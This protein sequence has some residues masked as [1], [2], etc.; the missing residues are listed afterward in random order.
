MSLGA[1]RFRRSSRIL[2]AL[3][4]L[5]SSTALR[6]APLPPEPPTPP[7]V[8]APYVGD[9]GFRPG[10]YAWLRGMFDGATAT[11]VA[12]DAAIKAWRREC[13]E[14]DVA[15]VREELRELGVVAGAALNGMPYTTVVCGQVASIPQPLELDDW[16]GFSRD[17]AI[18]RP[19]VDGYLAA[20]TLSRKLGMSD[21]GDL[22]PALIARALEEQTLRA[23]LVWSTNPS[24]FEGVR[25]DLS[26]RQRAI[27]RAAITIALQLE[28]HAN[29]LW[30]KKEVAKRGW[31]KRSEVGQKGAKMAWLLVQHADADPAFQ[32]SALRL[33]K[34]LVAEGEVDGRDFAYLFDRVMLRTEGRQRYGTQ[35]ACSKGHLEPLPME[36][37]TMVAARRRELGLS[38][39]ASYEAET[40]KAIGDCGTDAD[41]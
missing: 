27:F 22:G 11:Q 14:A 13:H 12:D 34:P 37:G 26:V 1:P 28:D 4:E 35:L 5:F 39:L 17:A 41:E 7:A 15:M 30:L 29:T 38:D 16:I 33:M 24:A 36:D 2:A 40:L 18:V 23:G 3:V 10:D 20:V 19:I 31:P 8:L 9:D 6:A 21:S 32:V 25:G